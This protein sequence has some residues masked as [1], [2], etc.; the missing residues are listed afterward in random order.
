MQ[1]LY[2]QSNILY[3]QGD[4]ELR[5]TTAIKFDSN[6]D[7]HLK[8]DYYEIVKYFLTTVMARTLKILDSPMSVHL[9]SNPKNYVIL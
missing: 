9:V 8:Y 4:I 2:G 7:L 6:T 1:K 3:R 5:K